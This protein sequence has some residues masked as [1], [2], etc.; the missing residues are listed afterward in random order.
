MKAKVF[1]LL[2]KLLIEEHN[3]TATEEDINKIYVFYKNANDRYYSL[4]N[5]M[6]DEYNLI[7]LDSEMQ[8]IFE[9]CEKG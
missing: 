4:F 2:K 9:I 1:F 5:Y 3:C 7:L 8:E 6:L